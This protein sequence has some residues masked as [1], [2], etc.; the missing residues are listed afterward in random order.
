MREF[1][2]LTGV[3]VD[4][5]EKE[6]ARWAEIEERFKHGKALYEAAERADSVSL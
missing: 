3:Y 5:R 6:L 4:N 1:G 2:M